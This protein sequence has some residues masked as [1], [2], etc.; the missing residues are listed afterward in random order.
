MKKLLYFIG[1]ILCLASLTCYAGFSPG[2]AQIPITY[3]SAVTGAIGGG[4]LLLG[5]CTSGTVNIS[6]VDTGMAVMASPVT[7]P[8]AGAIWD[9]YVSA[10]GVVT[11]RVCAMVALT[12]V[13]TVYNVRVVKSN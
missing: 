10:A 1:F 11:V 13:S 5:A 4:L 8:G 6:G 12:P 7:N 2:D 9:A 3:Y